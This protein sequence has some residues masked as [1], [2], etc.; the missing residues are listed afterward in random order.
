[1]VKG[2]Y[3]LVLY[4]GKQQ[5]THLS[6]W[7]AN[8][9]CRIS[10]QMLHIEHQVLVNYQPFGLKCRKLTCI[11]SPCVVQASWMSCCPLAGVGNR[12]VQETKSHSL[13]SNC[14]CSQVK[15]TARLCYDSIG[16]IGFFF[17]FVCLEFKKKTVERGWSESHKQKDKH[18]DSES[19]PFCLTQ[20]FTSPHAFYLQVV[21][22]LRR[23]GVVLYA[24]W[25]NVL[26][27]KICE[28]PLLVVLKFCLVVLFL[29]QLI[30]SADSVSAHH[31]QTKLPL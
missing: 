2:T 25:Q 6:C 28:K 5:K 10:N 19:W 14:T 11:C 18:R 7:I 13:Q 12:A 21:M 8:S 27:Q 4:F 31:P 9:S 26:P 1:M 29:W 30:I 22:C 17:L 3:F 16:V 20:A 23:G 15:Y 24:D